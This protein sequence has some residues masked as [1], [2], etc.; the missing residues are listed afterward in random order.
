MEK[1]HRVIRKWLNCEER[2]KVSDFTK[3]LK[4]AKGTLYQYMAY[5][6]LKEPQHKKNKEKWLRGIY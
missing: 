5:T 4:M 3:R 6:G 2:E 1:N